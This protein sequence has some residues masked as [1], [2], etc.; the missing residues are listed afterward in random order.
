[1][2]VVKA[3]QALSDVAATLDEKPLNSSVK[4][5]GYVEPPTRRKANE[6]QQG[7]QS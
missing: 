7:A 1:M 2:A 3:A 6:Q 4:G 5:D